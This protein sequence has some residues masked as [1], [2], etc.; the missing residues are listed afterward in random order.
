LRVV[1]PNRDPAGRAAGDLLAPTACRGRHDDLGLA[2]GVHDTIGFIESVE[3][4]R[5]PGLALAPTAMT[6][7]ND[8][9]RSDQTISD[10][11]AGASTFH[12][13]LDIHSITSFQE[14]RVHANCER[15]GRKKV[16]ISAASCCG[17]SSAGKWPPDGMAWWVMI[18]SS[19]AAGVSSPSPLPPSTVR[20]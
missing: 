20:S 2:S 16:L 7:V 3:R 11:P 6:G 18:A 17:A 1:A 5:G 13:L 9:W 10:L 4:M 19:V 14:Q 12:V 15:S 8:Q